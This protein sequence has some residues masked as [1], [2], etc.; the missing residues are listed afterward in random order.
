V[1]LGNETAVNQCFAN[2]LGNAVKFVVPGTRPKVRVRAEHTDSHA[3]IWIE[4]NGIGIPKSALEKIFVPFHRGRSDYEG[5]GL[6]L[7]LVSRNMQRMGGRVGVESE[8]GKGSRFWLEFKIA[9]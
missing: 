7:A 4:D 8:E 6:G 5:T 9:V 3:R 2:L 1:I